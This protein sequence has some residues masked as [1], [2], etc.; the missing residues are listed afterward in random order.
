MPLYRSL[1]SSRSTP[2]GVIRAAVYLRPASH[3]LPATDNLVKRATWLSLAAEALRV[4]RAFV[5]ARTQH[6]CS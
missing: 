1:P 6:G 4:G 3:E 5:A 2:T